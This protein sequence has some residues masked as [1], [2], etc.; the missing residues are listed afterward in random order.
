[1]SVFKIALIGAGRMG[2]CHAANIAGHSKLSLHYVVDPYEKSLR[3]MKEQY[4]CESATLEEALSDPEIDGLVIC[5][6]THQHT[7]HIQSALKADKAAFCEKP[8]GL[9]IK[10]TI[11]AR[12]DKLSP[13]FL[14]GFNRRFDPHTC[15]LR[16]SLKSQ[17]IGKIESMR[18]VNHDPSPPSHDFIPTSGGMFL[19]FT[20]H[21]LDTAAWLL[22][23]PV[24]EVFAAGSCLIDPI[25]GEMGDI[26]T[27]R[28]ILKTKS[29]KL[30][31]ISNSRRSGCGYDQRIEIFGSKGRLAVG[32]ISPTTLNI[33]TEKCASSDA[34]LPN[35]MM[36]YAE[37][38]AAEMDHFA[39]I[40]MGQT[41]PDIGYED[42][43]R[44]QHLAVACQKSL[45]NNETVKINL[46]E[47]L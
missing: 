15:A 26:D 8:I 27:A 20:I 18:I 1:M 4:G 13:P 14:L 6:A 3:L 31:S 12:P 7:V 2:Q 39:R 45:N 36:R 24:T 16:R 42:G 23:E 17:Q 40:L 9:D 44:A 28:V 41:Q 43:I 10:T 32:N 47:D 34:I 22:D 38:Y 35:F 37:S 29:G 33:L 46:S 25:I 30:C 5:S 11:A 19:D 21:D